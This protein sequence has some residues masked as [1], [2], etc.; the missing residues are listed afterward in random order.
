[1]DRNQIR[2]NLVF[3]A[4]GQW[5]VFTRAQALAA[6]YSA[7]EIRPSDE[8]PTWPPP[9]VRGSLRMSGGGVTTSPPT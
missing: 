4:D 3:V 7:D 6:G 1:M 5:G 2:P 8:G 9:S